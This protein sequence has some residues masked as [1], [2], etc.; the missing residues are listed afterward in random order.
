MNNNDNKFVNQEKDLDQEEE[1]NYRKL[2]FGD[3]NARMLLVIGICSVIFIV[4]KQLGY[5]LLSSFNTFYI[6]REMPLGAEHILIP[7]ILASILIIFGWAILYCSH[8]FFNFSNAKDK[9]EEIRYKVK[10]DLAFNKMLDAFIINMFLI[11]FVIIL[12]LLLFGL[13]TILNKVI[14]FAFL[15]VFLFA[16]KKE[17][18]AY[19][20]KFHTKFRSDKFKYGTCIGIWFFLTLL[21]IMFG[22]LQV[23]NGLKYEGQFIFNNNNGI[24][25]D[26]S[27]SNTLPDN[28]DILLAEDNSK[29]ITI[30][31][32]EFRKAFVEVSNEN[33]TN[34]SDSVPLTNRF[35]YRQSFYEYQ[36][37]VSLDGLLKE[38]K[39]TI[40]I[41]FKADR[42]SGLKKSCKLVNEI[43]LNNG[44]VDIFKNDLTVSLD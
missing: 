25:V 36:K 7:T 30:K 40:I 15:F 27:F 43:Y 32:S 17:I 8:E 11:A 26:I 21:I 41:T 33:Y 3:R 1:R 13:P 22:S 10:A 28:I 9:N 31:G 20:K 14:A 39:N 19:I 42:A 24:N 35:I 34:S 16:I 38:G 23:G 4:L 5:E 2:T 44:V 18:L 37:K 6:N 12:A 29:V